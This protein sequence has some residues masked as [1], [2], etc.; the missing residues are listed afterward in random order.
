MQR[1]SRGAKGGQVPR[2]LGSPAALL[3]GVSVVQNVVSSARRSV[4]ERG[5]VCQALLSAQ[6]DTPSRATLSLQLLFL[7]CWRCPHSPHGPQMLGLLIAAGERQSD[8]PSCWAH[9]LNGQKRLL[10]LKAC[11]LLVLALHQL[12]LALAGN[13]VLERPCVCP[14]CS[15]PVFHLPP[16]RAHVTS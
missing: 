8:G 6:Q 14:G 4:K 16:P 9:N 15:A 13:A 3:T 7:G 11:F 5:W 10:R 1:K 12:R 2:W